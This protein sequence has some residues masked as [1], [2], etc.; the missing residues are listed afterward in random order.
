MRRKDLIATTMALT[1]TVLVAGTMTACNSTEPSSSEVVS[2]EAQTEV[3]EEGYI[4][5]DVQVPYTAL[6][7]QD[8]NIYDVSDAKTAVADILAETYVTVTGDVSYNGVAVEYYAIKTEDGTTGLMEGKDL[9]FNVVTENDY[10][11]TLTEIEGGD[12]EE[13]TETTEETTEAESTEASSEIG[14]SGEAPAFESYVRYTNTNCNVRSQAN[15]NSD[16]VGTLSINSEVTVIGVE[17]DW[18]KVSY[19]GMEAFIKSSLLSESKTEVKSQ[20][21]SS[22]Q[23]S[24]SS[25]GG[26]WD[27]IL[28]G[29]PSSDDMV[30]G[31]GTTGGTELPNMGGAE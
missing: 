3:Q 15:K 24:S 10:V 22:G 1:L 14:V 21:S 19:N 16:L 23:S 25:D 6:V 20:S 11:D 26:N 9:D 4:I 30:N 8:T 13:T 5:T 2:T 7:I 29:L 27:A 18:S 31:G 17:N 28:D 12:G